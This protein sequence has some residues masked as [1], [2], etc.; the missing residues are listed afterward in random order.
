MDKKKKCQEWYQTMAELHIYLSQDIEALEIHIDEG[1]SETRTAVK[2]MLIY[3]IILLALNA[4]GV[5][6]VFELLF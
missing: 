1:N 5:S 3:I 4:F 6:S 2:W